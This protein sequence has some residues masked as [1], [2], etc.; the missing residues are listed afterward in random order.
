MNRDVVFPFASD[1]PLELWNEANLTATLVIFRDEVIIGTGFNTPADISLPSREM[2]SHHARII[3]TED[4][5]FLSDRVQSGTKRLV[6]IDGKPMPHTGYKQL[7]GGEIIELGKN[8]PALRFRRSQ[9]PSTTAIIEERN[10]RRLRITRRRQSAPPLSAFVLFGEA[11]IVSNQ[12][13]G[14]DLHFS[15]GYHLRDSLS[16]TFAIRDSALI[17]QLSSSCLGEYHS[18]KVDQEGTWV[19]LR[20]DGEFSDIPWMMR[21]FQPGRAG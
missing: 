10:R 18:V 1:R 21:L 3:R 2:H 20:I 13:N 15:S 11:L 17:G 16:M 8:S 7:L 4:R 19:D 6:R 12:A 9:L 14:G 5:Y